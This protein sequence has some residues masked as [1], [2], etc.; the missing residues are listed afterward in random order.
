VSSVPE[1]EQDAFIV[2]ETQRLMAEMDA[3]I[4]R[5]GLIVRDREKLVAVLI[6]QVE[7]KEEK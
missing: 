4:A 2:A 6:E 7:P 1:D 3:L 5:A